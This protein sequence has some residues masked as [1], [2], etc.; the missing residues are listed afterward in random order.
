MKKIQINLDHLDHFAQKVT[1]GSL[2]SSQIMFP[3]FK[4]RRVEIVNITVAIITLKS[5]VCR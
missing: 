2:P 1:R 4:K 3:I 5:D